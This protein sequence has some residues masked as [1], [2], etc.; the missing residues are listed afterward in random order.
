[1]SS[2]KL[3]SSD[4]LLPGTGYSPSYGTTDSTDEPVSPTP[5]SSSSSE[6]AGSKERVWV[7]ARCALTACLAS[8]VVG[9]SGGYNS[10]AL[11]ELGNITIPVQFISSSSVLH[12]FFAVCA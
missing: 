6:G 10:P 5:S 2:V 11:Q 1:M 9:M 8:F 4:Q 7:L 12:S 3:G